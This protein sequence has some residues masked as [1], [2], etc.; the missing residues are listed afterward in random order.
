MCEEINVFRLEMG[1][2]QLLDRTEISIRRSA[3]RLVAAR[4]RHAILLRRQGRQ[5]DSVVNPTSFYD[6]V[7]E[8]RRNI[9]QGFARSIG[10]LDAYFIH[11]VVLRQA[12]MQPQ[13]ILRKVAG[14]AAHFVDLH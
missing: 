5:G 4:K 14:A 10:P 13:I 12:K 2:F 7:D 9:A 3:I 6:G 8:V 1:P 11:L